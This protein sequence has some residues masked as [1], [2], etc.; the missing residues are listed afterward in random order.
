MVVFSGILLFMESALI[1]VEARGGVACNPHCA[2]AEYGS[3]F[4]YR[5]T[6]GCIWVY[7]DRCMWLDMAVHCCM[8][9]YMASYGCMWPYMVV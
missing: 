4:V 1:S 9:L 7:I 3:V 5:A 8:W 2:S 6:Y